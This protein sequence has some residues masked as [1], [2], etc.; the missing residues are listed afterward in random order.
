MIAASKAMDG[1]TASANAAKASFDKVTSAGGA[2]LINGASTGFNAE[3]NTFDMSEYTKNFTQEQL[4][5][6]ANGI[7]SDGTISDAALAVM[8]LT[9]DDIKNVGSAYGD[10]TG[11]AI[12]NAIKDGAVN[13]A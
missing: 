3:D 1:V 10:E 8:K 13:A 12:A 11:A 6:I 9:A 7:S 5:T 4:N 2:D